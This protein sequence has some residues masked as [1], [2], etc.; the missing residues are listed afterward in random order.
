MREMML[1]RWEAQT[2]SREWRLRSDCPPPDDDDDDISADISYTKSK[3]SNFAAP[4][5]HVQVE[6]LRQ[7]VLAVHRLQISSL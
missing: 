7:W 5:G 2:I 1:P 6:I 3:K 4:E